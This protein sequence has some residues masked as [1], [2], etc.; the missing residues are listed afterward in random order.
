M[1]ELD[2]RLRIGE[3]AGTDFVFDAYKEHRIRAFEWESVRGGEKI[4]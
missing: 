1:N 2:V 4:D 3:G